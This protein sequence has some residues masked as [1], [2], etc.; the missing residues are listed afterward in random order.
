MQVKITTRGEFLYLEYE[1][2]GKRVRKSSGL[3]D[4]K[5][6]VAYVY[7]NVI[8]ELERK[9]NAGVDT[10][11]S[12]K[13]SYFLD[14]VIAKT[15]AERKINTIRVYEYGI[16]SFMQ[17]VGD[18]DV[19]S[20]GV[21]DIEDFLRNL[22]AKTARAYIAPISLAFRLAVKYD[23]IT[24]NPCSYAD[25][26]KIKKKERRAFDKQSVKSLIDY[27]TGELKTFL[28]IAFYTGA[29]AKEILALTWDDIK[30]DEIIISKTL[31]QNTVNS[32]KNGKTRRIIMPEALKEYLEGLDKSDERI[33]KMEY[34]T[35]A[36]KFKELQTTLG[37]AP[38]SLHITRHTYASLL[39]D[40]G[41]K[42]TLAQ[43]MLGHSSLV[44]TS[45]Y[46]HYLK[47]Q[48]DKT[49]LEKALF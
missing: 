18:K 43:E 30:S 13:L 36:K 47:N 6:N 9:L 34:R 1:Q 17:E 24:K 20:Y 23:I 26:P 8:P 39:I 7:R 25:F 38:Q 4:T 37:L 19:S 41:V 49:E 32:P 27:A 16:R 29:R 31:A 15:R 5:A 35:I 48:N 42:P 11:K 44:M 21:R 2:N 40:A 46:T 10:T 14:R 12:Y 3:K 28:F 45:L 33:L 22:N